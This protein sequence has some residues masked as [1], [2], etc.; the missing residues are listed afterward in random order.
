M[1]LY[2]PKIMYFSNFSGPVIREQLLPPKVLFK[3]KEELS[4]DTVQSWAKEKRFM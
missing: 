3:N 4:P 2:P 1:Y